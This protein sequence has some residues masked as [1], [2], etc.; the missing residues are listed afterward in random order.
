MAKSHKTQHWIP[1]SYLRAWADPNGPAAHKS[2]VHVFSKDGSTSRKKAPE[3]LF[4]ETELYTIRLPDG[5]RDLRLE[6]GLCGFEASF[7]EMRRDYLSKRKHVPL[8][9]YVKLVDRT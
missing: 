5:G 1:R 4:T 8:P 9:R 7:S 6:H 3:N 2:Y